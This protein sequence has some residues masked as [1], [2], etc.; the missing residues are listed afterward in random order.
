MKHP[1]DLEITELQSL[2]LEFQEVTD[3]EAA[4]ITGGLTFPF[5]FDL[6]ANGGGFPN[7]SPSSFQIP[8]S[9]FQIPPFTIGG[10]GG[11]GQA[12][13]LAV[14]EEGGDV[15]TLAVGEEGGDVTT[16]AVGE[17]GGDTIG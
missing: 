1:F 12:T 6:G 10:N 11:G 5:T 17:E 9:S 3:K 15:T 8:A 7:P 13:T 16:L 4:E 14:G 2:N